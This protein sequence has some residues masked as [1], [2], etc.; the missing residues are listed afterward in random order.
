MRSRESIIAAGNGRTGGALAIGLLGPLDVSVG[1]RPV[2]LTAGRLRAVLAVL[3]LSAG[4]AVSV[5][6][7][8][9]SVWGDEKPPGNVRRSVQTY[10]ARLRGALGA[11]SIGSAP[12]G[13]V[14]RADHRH[15]DAL[16]FSKLLSTANAAAGTGAERAFLG[17]ALDL[18]RGMPFEGVP[19]AWLEA[20]KAPGMVE[21]YLT[22]LE[23]RIDLD[24][25]AGRHGE[26]IGE[27]SDLTARYPLREPLW[28]RLLTVLDRAGRRAEALAGYETVRG[29]IAAEFGVDPDPALQRIHASL[30]ARR[31]P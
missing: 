11:E 6:R 1:E 16:R 27:L 25:A 8:A 28:A 18:W 15:V 14:L 19:S 4:Q 12:T 3:A 21:Q 13:Y 22:A 17:E 7:L 30:L 2:A 29:R 31:H 9:V 10:I 23:R 26:I 20:S 24:I 5:E